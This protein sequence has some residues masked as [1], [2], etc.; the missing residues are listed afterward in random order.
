MTDARFSSLILG[1]PAIVFACM[2]PLSLYLGYRAKVSAEKAE[3]SSVKAEAKMNDVGKMLDGKT[4][5]L[6]ALVATAITGRRK[7]E[8]ESG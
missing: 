3:A 8:G 2:Q 1:I 4:S 6:T 7:V 5:E